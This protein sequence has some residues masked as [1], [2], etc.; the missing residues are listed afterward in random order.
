MAELLIKRAKR[1]LSIPD[2]IV[3]KLIPGWKFEANSFYKLFENFNSDYELA[4]ALHKFC[5]DNIAYK[6]DTEGI[7]EIRSPQQTW[8]DRNTGVDCEDYV[9][10][11]STILSKLKRNHKIRVVDF[12]KNGYDHIF[13]VLNK[14]N[15][16]ACL[17]FNECIEYKLKK[18]YQ[19]IT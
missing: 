2:E 16:D 11:M 6:P 1:N 19:I 5:V 3:N 15:L 12:E 18:D 17:D 4:K 13:I 9:I 8:N 14:F 7:E 10:F